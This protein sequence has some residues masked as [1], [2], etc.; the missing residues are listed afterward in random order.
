MLV[1]SF[2]NFITVSLELALALCFDDVRD[3]VRDDV[4]D[5]VSNCVGARRYGS[6]T[7]KTFIG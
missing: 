2:M 4:W 3:D 6:S 7:S 1:I 5:D